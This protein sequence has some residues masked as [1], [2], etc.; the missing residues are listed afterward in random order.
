MK[1]ASHQLK[2]VTV[3]SKKPL[4]E[5][6]ADKIIINV[7]GS[8]NSTGSTAME[9]LQKS[10]GVTVDNNDNISMKGKTGVKI[11]VDGRMT[12]L[13]SKELAA[14]LKG[15]NSN[16]IEAIE[17]ISNP[18]ARYDASGNAGIINIRLKKNKKRGFNGS[19]NATYIQGISPKGNGSVNLNYRNKNINIFGNFSADGGN[20]HG[21]LNFDRT[22]RDTTY[23]Q[24]SSNLNS[25]LN[26]NVKAGIDYNLSSTQIIGLLV[27]TSFGNGT[28]SSR[29]NTD[30]YDANHQLLK[31]LI[32][33]NSVPENR[34]NSNVNLNYKFADTNGRQLN[35]DADYGLFRKTSNS[36]QP[37]HYV[38]PANDPL[39]AVIN[40][41][42]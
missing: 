13:D 21:L 36:L 35:I 6:K 27:T 33:E 5:V 4:I 25:S 17:M 10:P 37:N 8:I 39:Y 19:V 32:A 29:S 3:S 16:D 20:R 15:I 1:P 30:I 40:R 2:T 42:C 26:E 18:S 9:L 7:E 28:W 24:R 22:Q 14:Y 31:R 38:T 12:Q 23:T 41:S 34:A 11:Y